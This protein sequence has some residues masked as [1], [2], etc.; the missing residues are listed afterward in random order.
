MS[1]P[2]RTVKYKGGDARITGA[3]VFGVSYPFPVNEDG[4]IAVKELTIPAGVAHALVTGEPDA[5]AYVDAPATGESVDKAYPAGE[6]G[7][8]G[9]GFESNVKPKNK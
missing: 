5:F 2:K 9:R 8:G 7:E 1:E 6:N 4:K 3:T